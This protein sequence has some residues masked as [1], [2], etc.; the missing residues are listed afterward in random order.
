MLK[1]AAWLICFLFLSIWASAY[2]E[3]RAI[4]LA[5]SADQKDSIGYNIV[6]DVSHNVYEWIQS[7]QVTLWDTPEKK[8]AINKADLAG[9]EASNGTKFVK[10]DNLFIYEN[11][12]SKRKKFKCS[13]KGIAFS[14]ENKHGDKVL[15]GYV[16][17]S[18]ELEGLLAKTL[19]NV[20]ANGNYGM[21]LLQGLMNNEFDFTLIF[22]RDQILT[23]VKRGN[24]LVKSALNPRKKNLSHMP[25]AEAKQVQYAI[26]VGHT[27]MAAK[28][29]AILDALEE[30]FNDNPQEY[31]NLGGD[32]I[33]SFLKASRIILTGC[34]V[35][36][37]RYRE[38]QFITTMPQQVTFYSIGF[39]MKSVNIE[40]LKDWGVEID[41][42]NIAD[43]LIQKKYQYRIVQINNTPIP[44][45][46]AEAYQA[47]LDEGNWQQIIQKKTKADL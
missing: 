42:K 16:E 33:Q 24:Q 17:Y 10:L 39:E 35:T 47:A 11:W 5:S 34:N 23:D 30:F 31:Y 19:M 14:D 7:G 38:R 25:V 15:Y 4:L 3:R 18:P 20:N 21:T 46:Q 44:K 43:I 41:D 32:K 45:E 13:I 40:Q 9:I 28:T 22:F 6:T 36:E 37:V 2:T 1:P 26:E 8:Y 12:T 27:A 29:R